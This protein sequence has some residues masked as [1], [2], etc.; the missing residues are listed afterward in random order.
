MAEESKEDGAGKEFGIE[1]GPVKIQTKGYHLGNVLQMALVLIL[2]AIAYMTYEVKVDA[3]IAATTLTATTTKTAEVLATVSKQEHDKLGAAI[4]RNTEATVESAYIL[5]LNQQ[6]RE[7][8][9]IRMPESM[10]RKVVGR[11]P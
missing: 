7:R 10:R 3:K 5:T 1:A 9:N 4:E 11:D 8:L 6:Q 2:A